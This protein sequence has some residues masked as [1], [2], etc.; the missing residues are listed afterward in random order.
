MKI[1][2]KSLRKDGGFDIQGELLSDDEDF[3]T[4]K[5]VCWLPNHKDLLVRD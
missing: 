4:T 2:E 5:K 1:V 3:K